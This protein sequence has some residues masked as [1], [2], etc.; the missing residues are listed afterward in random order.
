MLALFRHPPRISLKCNTRLTNGS[1][2][3]T[4]PLRGLVPSVA[5]LPRPPLIRIVR[6]RDDTV[7]SVEGGPGIRVIPPLLYV[8]GFLIGVALEFVWPV[9][10]GSWRVSDIGGIVFICLSVILGGPAILRFRRA[11]TPFDVRKPATALVTEGP[12]RHS[13][14]P[15]YLALTLLYV[16]V[17]LLIESV[18]V[19]VLLVPVL[20]VMTS[21][22]IRNEEQHLEEV[23]GEEYRMY[24]SQVRRWV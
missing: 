22:V 1:S 20:V 23:F 14:N 10:D 19:V 3:T 17:A 9:I 4:K 8:V 7:S 12:Y 5:T 21:A 18:W 24:K 16:G 15:G 11:S 6:R 13:R 2:W